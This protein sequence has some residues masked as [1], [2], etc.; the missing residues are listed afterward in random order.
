MAALT[1][2]IYSGMPTVVIVG[3]PNVGK[4]TLFNR[5]VG[6]RKAVVL[7]TPGMT[8]DRNF[9]TAEWNGRRF[10]L[11]DT[12]GYE[13]EPQ[14]AIY[15]QM[16]EQ[17]LLAVEE[18]DLVLLMLD[19]LQPDNPVDQ[20]VVHILRRSGKPVLPVVNKCD[21][22]RRYQESFCFY[23]LGVDELYP[24]SALN[25]DGTG[26]L[27]DRVVE[28]LPPEPEEVEEKV[29]GI[30]VAVIG[31]PNVGKSSLVN[32]ILGRPRVITSDIPGTTRDTIDTTFRVAEEEEVSPTFQPEEAGY[33]E[34]EEAEEL[35]GPKEDETGP[36]IEELDEMEDAEEI[37]DEPELEEEPEVP[38]GPSWEGRVYTLIDTAGLR[39]RGKIER[40]V[41]KLCSFAAQASL[42]RCDVALILIDAEQG[43][44]EQDKHVA[45]FA[46]EANRG[47]IFVVNKWD[48]LKKDNSTA[49]AFAR[50]IRDAFGHM[51]YA[52]IIMVSAR[53]GQRVHRLLDLIDQV[54]GQYTK[55]VETAELNRWLKD[56]IQRLSPP[57]HK[58]RQL[59]MKYV[60]QTGIRPPTFA[61]YV[62]NPKYLHFSYER[63]LLNRLRER[64]DFT[65]V[66]LRLF[67]RKKGRRREIPG[68]NL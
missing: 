46:H 6:R 35:P 10:A 12:G 32:A 52:P 50:D 65:G 34:A 68:E 27:L 2:L 67:F 5:L 4:S 62:N 48:L 14:D 42:R 49:G 40:G 31:R 30:R 59:R 63:Y 15:S 21:N 61:F 19:V 8:R 3:R 24:V 58:G 26:D 22:T 51:T 29:E 33:Y 9:D 57:W 37:E 7:D 54:Y 43:I 47:C 1:T 41:E 23:A 56:S 64:F 60:T 55:R 39:R 36:Y 53:T 45:G 16:R 66:A 28:L 38:S 44:T 11:V 17:C 20:D 18:A 13:S 25:G